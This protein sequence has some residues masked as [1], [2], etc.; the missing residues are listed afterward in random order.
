MKKI[1]ITSHILHILFKTLCWFLPLTTAYIILFKMEFLLHIGFWSSIFSTTHIVTPSHHYSLA[2][3]LVILVIQCMPL[4][5]TLMIFKKLAQLFYLYEKGNLFE[6]ENIRLI[7]GVSIY[8]ILGE[9]IQLIYQ[10]LITAALTFNN[11]VGER[12]ASITLGTT[13]VSTL[14]TAFIIL[15]ASWILKEANQLK[16]ES[17][18]TI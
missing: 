17:Q 1:Q 16:T 6:E 18:L 13:N 11:P 14:I 4:S 7:K 2:H 15:V 10:P 3:R 12:L 5:I 9:L 8:M